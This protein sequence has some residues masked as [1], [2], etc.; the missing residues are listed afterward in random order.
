M[1]YIS[2][3]FYSISFTSPILVEPEVWMVVHQAT[4]ELRPLRANQGSATVDRGLTARFLGVLARRTPAR[5]GSQQKPYANS[6]R[7]LPLKGFAVLIRY[8]RLSGNNQMY[9]EQFY[10]RSSRLNS[11]KN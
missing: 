8:S 9:S 5:V 1:R 3:T 10:P 7:M 6:T 11:A 4:V 2:P